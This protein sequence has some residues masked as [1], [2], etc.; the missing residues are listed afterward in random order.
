MIFVSR[1]FAGL[2]IPR[3]FLIN[4]GKTE[5]GFI[6]ALLST[7]KRVHVDVDSFVF[8]VELHFIDR[9]E[10]AAKGACS[11]FLRNVLSRPRFVLSS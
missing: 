10:Q 4:R 5:K 6:L 2:H 3:R 7:M 11:Q 1:F 9:E 8:V